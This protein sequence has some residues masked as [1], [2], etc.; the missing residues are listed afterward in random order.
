VSC[1]ACGQSGSLKALN[2][3][4]E[5]NRVAEPVQYG[6]F[7]KTQFVGGRAGIRWSS[8]PMPEHMLRGLL[9]QL[10]TAAAQVRE[11]LALH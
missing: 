5:G 7:L 3:D 2:F 1:P 4:D 9:V 10:E 11:L 8:A 6:A